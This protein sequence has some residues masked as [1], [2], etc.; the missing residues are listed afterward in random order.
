MIFSYSEISEYEKII[1]LYDNVRL[2]MALKEFL[3]NIHT[4]YGNALMRRT[5][6]M[7]ERG[8]PLYT[9]RE[10]EIRKWLRAGEHFKTAILLNPNNSMA[11]GMYEELLKLP[12]VVGRDNLTGNINFPRLERLLSGLNS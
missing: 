3:S 1:K 10:Q 5:G 8:V 7:F 9:V 2:D 6:E 11:C 4:L 12:G